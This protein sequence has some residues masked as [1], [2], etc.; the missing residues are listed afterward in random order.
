MM[1]NGKNMQQNAP[2]ITKKSPLLSFDL[3]E[4]KPC[5]FES[6][7]RDMEAERYKDK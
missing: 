7:I 6:T 1:G 5:G 3:L 4:I 2:M